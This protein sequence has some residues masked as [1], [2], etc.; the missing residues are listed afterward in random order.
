MNADKRKLLAMNARMEGEEVVL[1]GIGDK[2]KVSEMELICLVNFA[3]IGL[4]SLFANL[5]GPQGDEAAAELEKH[6]DGIRREFSKEGSD[7][8]NRLSQST[9]ALLRG[10]K[11]AKYLV[12][13]VPTGEGEA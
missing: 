4:M 6:V 3:E 8:L 12:A 11:F 1:S 2:I 13:P 9:A 10:S 7:G 5:D